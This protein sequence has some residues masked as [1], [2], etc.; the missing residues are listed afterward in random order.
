MCTY[1]EV[2]RNSGR[3]CPVVLSYG[4]SEDISSLHLGRRLFLISIIERYLSGLLHLTD[5]Y[6]KY[7][8]LAQRYL[9]FFRFVFFP[10]FATDFFVADCTIQ[11]L[12]SSVNPRSSSGNALFALHRDLRVMF[13]EVAGQREE[14]KAN[15]G[16]SAGRECRTDCESFPLVARRS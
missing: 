10:P 12:N 14:G 7:I 16:R 9:D 8:S 2:A 5:I 3:L 4:L 6:I 13:A 15:H 11:I 1:N